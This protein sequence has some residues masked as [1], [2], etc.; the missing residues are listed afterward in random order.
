MDN[1]VGTRHTTDFRRSVSGLCH[2]SI[3]GSL[4]VAITFRRG[5]CNF[6]RSLRRCS[7]RGAYGGTN[8]ASSMPAGWSTK[9]TAHPLSIPV[10]RAPEWRCWC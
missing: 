7:L 1:M 2:G 4:G 10:S 3:S 6:R 8:A 5:D 9:R